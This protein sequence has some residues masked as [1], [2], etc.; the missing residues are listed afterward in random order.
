MFGMKGFHV[1]ASGGVQGHSGP[2]V[3]Y[4]ARGSKLAPPRGVTV[5]NI[6]TKKDNWGQN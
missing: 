6:G 4:D 1:S 3:S 5:L 2:L